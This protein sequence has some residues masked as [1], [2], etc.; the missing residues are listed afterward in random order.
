MRLQLLFLAFPVIHAAAIRWM[1]LGDSITDYGCWRA[2][3]WER[4]QNEG[5]DVDLVGGE[6]AG[7]NCR[8]LDF[9]RDHEGH[10]GYMA[11]DIVAKKQLVD[12]LKKNPADVVTMHLGT[13]DIFRG[14]KKTGEILEAYTTLV[15]VMRGSNPG[16][17]IIV[18]Q[19]IPLP[20]VDRQVQE[21]NRAIPAWAESK[22]SSASPIW[23]VDQWTGFTSADLKDGIHP[24][25]SGDA[26]MAE[27]FWPALVRAIGTIQGR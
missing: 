21:L 2:W 6:R 17:R 16:M 12:W 20:A 10:P 23:L 3:L 8:G 7:E 25:E 19:I 15:D 5:Y 11:V 9:D 4:F 24:S 14:N 13:N 22:N 26:K 1:P 18:A 27:R